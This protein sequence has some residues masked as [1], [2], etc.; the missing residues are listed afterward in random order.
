MGPG[1]RRGDTGFLASPG[2]FDFSRG[3]RDDTEFWERPCRTA[4]RLNRVS[5]KAPTKERTHAELQGPRGR[6]PLPVSRAA[7]N[8]QARR[9]AG[10]RRSHPRHD[11]R[12]PRRR[13]E[14]LRRGFAAAEPGRRRAWLRAGKRRGAHTPRLQGG[15]PE[16][17]RG[18]LEPARRAGGSGRRGA[19][20]RH[21][22][23]L[24]R[25]GH[26]REPGLRDVSGPD[27]RGLFRALGDGRAL[28]ARACGEE[29]DL[30]R[31]DRHHVP[32][33]APLRH[34]PEADE[35][36]GGGAGRRHLP[37][38]RHQD[39]HLGRR[40]RHDRQHHPHGDRE[41]SRRGRQARQRSLDGQFFHGTEDA[42]RQGNRRDHRPQQCVVRLHRKE[43]GHQG[44]R[45]RRSELRRRRCL[46]AGRRAGAE[47]KR[48]RRREKVEIGRHGGHVRHDERRAH[49]RRHSRHRDRRSGLSK[50]RRLRE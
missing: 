2:L 11:G 32:H 50:R 35:N 6:L 14:I 28:D 45:H 19:A 48:N 27:H 39:F 18:W 33:R 41:N 10:I 12:H 23:R 47:E 3:P 34:R 49:G 15:S 13:R 7:G 25:N 21:H 24:H 17:L 1:F 4:D 26:V 43:D 36:E 20:L 5:L 37:R 44:E 38:L 31:M 9:R 29:D 30:G 8:R 22:L 16:I 46:Q 42:G 40:P